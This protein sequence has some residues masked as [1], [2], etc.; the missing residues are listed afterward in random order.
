M[1]LKEIYKTED[2][3]HTRKRDIFSNYQRLHATLKLIIISTGISTFYT[4]RMHLLAIC[5]IL[6]I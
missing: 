2:L 4:Y 6:E 1:D 3:L 5:F